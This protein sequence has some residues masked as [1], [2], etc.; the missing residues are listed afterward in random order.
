M[1]EKAKNAALVRMDDWIAIHDE[2]RKIFAVPESSMLSDEEF[3]SAAR[4]AQ[5]LSP[6]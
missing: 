3:R 2:M 5:P 1:N 4:Q 6:D